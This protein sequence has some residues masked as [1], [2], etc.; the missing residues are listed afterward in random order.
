MDKMNENITIVVDNREIESSIGKML[1]SYGASVINSSLEIADYIL[2]ERVA[3]E[4]KTTTDFVSSIKDGRLFSQAEDMVRNFEAPVL[5]IEGK[6][7]YRISGMHPNAIRGAIA[8][9][10]TNYK[11]PVLQTN[12][13]EETAALMFWIAKR[14]QIDEKKQVSIHGKKKTR[15]LKEEQEYLVAGM[16]KISRVIARRLLKHFGSPANVFSANENDL[17]EVKG[18]GQNIAKIIKRLL[19]AE[20]C[21]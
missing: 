8:S 7:I 1:E 17:R 2:S 10:I 19:D 16:P 9:I 3:V 20:Y 12:S 15:T 21:D 6:N 11:I 5:V 13:A 18:V 4:R 14:E